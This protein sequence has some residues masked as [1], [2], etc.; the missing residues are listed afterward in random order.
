[1]EHLADPGFL[2]E[3]ASWREDKWPN[4]V[5]RVFIQ[6]TGREPPNGS[7]LEFAVLV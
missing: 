5:C 2:R 3:G 6:G 4:K 7:L 1:M